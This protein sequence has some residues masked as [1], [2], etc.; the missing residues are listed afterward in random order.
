MANKGD[1]AKGEN[2]PGGKAKTTDTPTPDRDE[3]SILVK[4]PPSV[5][6]KAQQQA[7]LA[8]QYGWIE[9]PT[10]KDLYIWTTMFYLDAG[11][12]AHIQQRR[13][14]LQEAVNSESADSTPS[15]ESTEDGR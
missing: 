8:Y 3:V 1:Q 9:S 15:K 6:E 11:I 5:K 4:V 7:N 2:K 12:K 10:F 13:A 14:R